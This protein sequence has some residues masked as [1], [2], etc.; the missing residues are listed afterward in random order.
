LVEAMDDP[1]E[2]TRHRAARALGVWGTADSIMPLIQK[3][4]DQNERMRHLVMESLGKLKAEQAVDAISQRLTIDGDRPVASKA[5]QAIGGPKVEIVGQKCLGLANEGL[6]IE[7][8]HILQA[9]GTKNSLKI[10]NQ[11][12]VLAAQNKKKAIVDAVQT[13]M[14]AIQQRG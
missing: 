1:D 9:V 11:M 14:Q 7:G 3:V 12:G 2:G 13:A 6:C 4:T 8:C 10:L 5:L